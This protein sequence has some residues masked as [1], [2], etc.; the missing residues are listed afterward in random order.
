MR[1]SVGLLALAIFSLPL[2][3]VS[4]SQTTPDSRPRGQAESRP[5]SGLAQLDGVDVAVVSVTP[6][7]TPQGSL[8]LKELES[9]LADRIG[10]INRIRLIRADEPRPQGLFGTARLTVNAFKSRVTGDVIYNLHLEVE[11]PV[12][13]MGTTASVMATV[14][15]QGTVGRANPAEADMRDAIVSLVRRMDE[16][17]AEANADR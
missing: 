3:V 17:M 5:L 4:Q 15:S 9:L 13:V 14:W 6:G 7:R 12:V 10:K 2:L 8:S 16:A 11:R 1:F